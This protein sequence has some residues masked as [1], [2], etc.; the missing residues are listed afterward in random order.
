MW[1]EGGSAVIPQPAPRRTWICIEQSLGSGD[2]RT[3]VWL[4]GSNGEAGPSPSHWDV[5]AQMLP[6][7]SGVLTF[8][9]FE[10]WNLF[11]QQ[12]FS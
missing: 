8:L 9:L 3:A 5:S 2:T 11:S 1:R 6:R 10:L 7:N 12:N 4:R